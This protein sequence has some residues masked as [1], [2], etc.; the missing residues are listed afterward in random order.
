MTQAAERRSLPGDEMQALLL[1]DN[2][3]VHPGSE[4]PRASGSD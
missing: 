4:T 1:I 2:N 3:S